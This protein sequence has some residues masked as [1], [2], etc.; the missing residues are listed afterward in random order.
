[1]KTTQEVGNLLEQTIDFAKEN[2]HEFIT[3]E[4]LLFTLTYH[5]FFQE[6][7]EKCGGSINRLRE[8]LSQF[9][10]DHVGVE[11]EKEPSY[12]TGF[13][14][15]LVDAHNQSVSCEKFVVE[16]PH[17]I[18]ALLQLKESHAVYFILSQNIEA[19]SLLYEICSRENEIFQEE[20]LQKEEQG[21]EG[22]K[23]Q[24]E[25][26]RQY[27]EC[28]N[29][30]VEEKNPLIGREQ[31]LLRTIQILCR[32]DKNNPLHIGEP[33][34]G[35]TALTYGLAYL[36]EN[37]AT[38]NAK[39]NSFI[40]IPKVLQG[41]KV[42]AIDLGGMLA[43]TKYR[44]EFEKRF[45]MVMKG[46]SEQEKPIVYID[47]IHT[48]VGAGA[49]N[50]GNFDVA[51]MLKPY[52]S[53]GK[54]RFIGATTYEE[55]KKYFSKNKSL[56]RR[57]QNIDI[58]EP[59]EEETLKIL[60]GLKK[61]Y[62]AYH[63]VKYSKGVLEYAV[64][65]SAK[66]Q[67][68]RFLPDKA[69]DLIDEAGAYRQIHPL[70]QKTQTVGKN[71]I[72]EVISKICNIPKKLVEQDELKNLALLE[73]KIATKVFGQEDAVA[74]VVKA[75][76]YSRAG[77]LE[78][79]KP[80]ASLLFVGPTGVGKT[81]VAKVLAKELCIDFLRFDMSE[82]AEKHTVA[83]LIGSPA[84]YVG[85]EEGGILTEE[86][87]KHPHAVLLLD[88]MEKAHADIYNILL[89]VMDYA[90]LTDNQGRKADFRN[91]ILI[92]TSNAGASQIGK[93]LIG[94]GGRTVQESVIMDS[95]KKTFQ[96]EFRNRLSK[97][98]VFSH[99]SDKMANQI[100]VKKLEELKNMLL[101]KQVEL[102]Y[103]DQVVTYIQEKGIS[104][105]YGAREIE[106]V[107]HDE[108]KPLFV[109]ELLFGKLKKGGSCKLSCKA[110]GVVVK[111]L[112]R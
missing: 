82:Y 21:S 86:I 109:D 56:V 31:E 105:E 25:S 50:D 58:K 7:F 83:K 59:S 110:E 104:K 103:E 88:E 9:F 5:P 70:N 51:N 53:E 97:I 18:A 33:G 43:G 73:A 94:Y 27:V 52:L 26:F 20:N 45:K 39:T 78:E 63:G 24:K 91:I 66:Y 29:D 12:T 14:Q 62:E 49:V 90:T 23:E 75:I 106:R 6:A 55:Y 16:L 71:L 76:K 41:A 10:L 37:S 68:E 87:R 111:F 35:K 40:S 80:L 85:Y 95:V 96:P 15:I 17:I 44:G 57:F 98:V 74:Q 79:G 34:V 65:F 13:K 2:F 112:K 22:E 64:S 102:T 1:M 11:K 8:R 107:I 42:Y 32:K 81:E 60:E 46:I 92:M 36:L 77:L 93:D 89:Q 61:Y 19:T 108:I 101:V 84:G 3:P 72:D 30:K 99:L 48:I 4:H 67:R 28:F 38:A 100:T 69:I 47:E 54:I